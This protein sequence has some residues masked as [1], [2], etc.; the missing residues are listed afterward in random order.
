MGGPPGVLLTA[1]AAASSPAATPTVICCY[2]ETAGFGA[3]VAHED[4]AVP[5]PKPQLPCYPAKDGKGRDQD[6]RRVI[7]VHSEGFVLWPQG[8]LLS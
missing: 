2:S 6:R 1:D 5:K 3:P 8:N 7:A 4:D